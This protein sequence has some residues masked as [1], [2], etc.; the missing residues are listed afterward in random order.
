M[1]TREEEANILWETEA[2]AVTGLVVI[3]STKFHACTLT[4][5]AR[6][7]TNSHSHRI[8]ICGINIQGRV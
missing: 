5:F 6:I 8:A 2:R 1:A 4:S 3:D 7:T